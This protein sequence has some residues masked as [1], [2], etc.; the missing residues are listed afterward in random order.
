M[1]SFDH[2]IL[3]SL[4]GLAH[5]SSSFDRIVNAMSGMHLLK[6]AVLAAALCWAW[7]RPEDPGRRNRRF[8]VAAL[9][10]S[11]VA[12]AAGRA[13]QL[14]LPFRP[15]PLHSP[16]IA[17]V[18]PYGEVP[19]VLDG[20]S[21]F[22]SDHA[23]MFFALST[24]LWFISHRAGVLAY[25]FSAVIVCLP[26][27][28]LGL[29]YPTDILA[30]A[31]LGVVIGATGCRT[32]APLPSIGALLRWIDRRAEWAYPVMFLLLYQVAEMFEDMRSLTSGV[33]KLLRSHGLF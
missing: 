16:E 17:F 9:V 2:T 1:N 4:N 13:L 24:G 32:M 26:R 30:G 29:H 8:V 33:A 6:G 23:V 21:S 15:R 28:F 20:W 19:T 14:L 3:M 31:A 10:S 7:F 5:Q 22:P 12:I 11:A 25:A 27:I 18:L